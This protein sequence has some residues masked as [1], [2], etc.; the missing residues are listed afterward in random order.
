MS[1]D[2]PRCTTV[3]PQWREGECDTFC[4][5]RDWPDPQRI[6]GQALSVTHPAR[7]RTTGA[8]AEKERSR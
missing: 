5:P 6:G 8:E 7:V 2:D 4:D 1:K 3:C